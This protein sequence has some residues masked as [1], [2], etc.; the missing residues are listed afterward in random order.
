MLL[1]N[2]LTDS[3]TKSCTFACAF[4]RKKRLEYLIKD[5]WAHAFTVITD[6][7]INIAIIGV[8]P[9]F[10]FAIRFFSHGLRGVIEQVHQYLVN[11]RRWA[12]YFRRGRKISDNLLMSDRVTSDFERGFDT[13]AHIDGFYFWFIKTGKVT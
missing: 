4:G 1:H 3:H 5:L 6:I 8:R 9:H 10:D 12:F 13:F 2:L 11:L 7:D